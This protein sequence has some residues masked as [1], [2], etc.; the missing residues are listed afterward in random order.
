MPAGPYFRLAAT[1]VP[2]HD[3]RPLRRPPT[4]SS[5]RSPRNTSK[6]TRLGIK[7]GSVDLQRTG[8]GGTIELTKVNGGFIFYP[9]LAGQPTTGGFAGEVSGEVRVIAGPLQVS[10]KPV[11]QINTSTQTPSTRRSSSTPAR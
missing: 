10:G 5:S 1:Q 2:R 8:A 7:N 9:Q 11:L 3:P 6:I 4:S